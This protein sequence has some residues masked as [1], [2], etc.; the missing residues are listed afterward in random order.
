MWVF[1]KHG[2]FSIVRHIDHPEFFLVRARNRAHL[3]NLANF[4]KD[5]W[6]LMATHE[7]VEHEDW[8][9]FARVT[10]HQDFLRRWLLETLNDVDYTTDVKGQIMEATDPELGHALL[11][12]W[13]RMLDYQQE[14][15]PGSAG[16]FH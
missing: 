2:F 14:V 12:V 13:A 5:R 6:G 10:I 3:E 11:D 8:D 15:H 9:Y 1:N 7:I 4:V 16:D